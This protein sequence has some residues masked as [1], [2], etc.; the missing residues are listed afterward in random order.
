VTAS[1][2]WPD[3]IPVVG[4]PISVVSQNQL[5]D[6]VQH[7]PRD[8]ATVVAFCNVHSVMTARRN[9]A[10]SAALHGSEVT[11]PDGMPVAWGLRAAGVSNQARVDG[12]TFMLEALRQSSRRGWSHYF[13]GSTEATLERLSDAARALSP[14]IQIAG[15]L[16]PP[17]QAP[18]EDRI[19][20]DAGRIAESGADLVWIGLGMPKQE[21][22]MHRARAYLPGVALLGVGA[23]FDFLAGTSS[24]APAWMQSAGLEWLHRF[25][26]QPGRLWRRYLINNP[27]YLFL[28]GKQIVAGRDRTAR[29][30]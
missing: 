15:V 4:T 11:S 28:L 19:R 17:F 23:A 8:T 7:R 26:Q 10:V 27:T 12:P 13:Y 1:P 5:L 14:G 25:S 22:W 20:D 30:D 16:S 21:L 24:R 18:T 2:E 29:T 3:R 9:P 6:L